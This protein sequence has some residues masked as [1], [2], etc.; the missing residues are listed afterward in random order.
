MKAPTKLTLKSRE[1]RPRETRS[2]EERLAALIGLAKVG[3]R[4]PSAA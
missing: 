4:R 2:R 3:P 1:A